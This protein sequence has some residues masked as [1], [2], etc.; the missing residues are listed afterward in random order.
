MLVRSRPV[1]S[2][3]TAFLDLV[4]RHQSR[5]SI[6]ASSALVRVLFSF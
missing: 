2:A 1:L 5:L 4:A 3:L 6:T